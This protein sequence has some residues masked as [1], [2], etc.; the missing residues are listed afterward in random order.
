MRPK[1]PANNNIILPESFLTDTLYPNEY[2][3]VGYFQKIDPTR[4]WTEMK[5]E[6]EAVKK[7][8]GQPASSLYTPSTTGSN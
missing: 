7:T 4:P 5:V 8:Y 6:I 2:K 1:D 3:C